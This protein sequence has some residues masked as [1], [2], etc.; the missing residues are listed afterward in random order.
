MTADQLDPAQL[1]KIEAMHQRYDRELD[2]ALKAR[3]HLWAVM[4][5]YKLTD[6]EVR[7]MAES[8]DA[9]E[10]RR[11][12]VPTS[13]PDRILSVTVGCYICEQQLDRRLIFRTCPGE[14]V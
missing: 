6:A 8:A 12:A 5:M 11:D 13:S 7:A 14:P 3:S 9:G 10:L 4:S 1:A 2:Y